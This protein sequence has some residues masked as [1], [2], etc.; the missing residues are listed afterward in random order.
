MPCLRDARARTRPGD[1]DGLTNSE[2][3]EAAREWNGR[4]PLG[5]KLTGGVDLTRLV[6]EKEKETLLASGRKQWAAHGFPGSSR[7]AGSSGASGRPTGKH[8]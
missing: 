1:S 5:G 2:R 3:S 7:A 8:A 6:V 4:W